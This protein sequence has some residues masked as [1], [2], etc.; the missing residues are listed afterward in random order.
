MKYFTDA[1][2]SQF[3]DDGLERRL[4]IDVEHHEYRISDS[5]NN[6]ADDEAVKGCAAVLVGGC[7]GQFVVPVTV[8]VPLPAPNASDRG[9]GRGSI[10]A[11]RITATYL[12]LPD[13]SSTHPHPRNPPQLVEGVST[14]VSDA[15]VLTPQSATEQNQPSG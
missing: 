12:A 15:V 2:G 1:H 6:G 4:R 7:S 8:E 11:Q 9:V 5:S 14:S 10:Q 3:T 13:H